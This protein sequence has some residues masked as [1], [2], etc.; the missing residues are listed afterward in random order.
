MTSGLTALYQATFNPRYL[1]A[2]EALASRAEALF[3]DE[4]QQAYLSAPRGMK[5][6]LVET[7]SL[8]DNAWPSGASTL[9]EAQVTLAAITGKREHL[10]R[11]ERY[12]TR[13][14]AQLQQNPIGYGHLLLAADAFLDGA[15]ELTLA[16]ERAAAAPLLAVANQTYAPTVALALHDPEAPVSGL[17][18]E[19]FTGREPVRGKPAAYLCRNFVCERPV[20]EPQELRERLGSVR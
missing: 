13:M 4:R 11:A 14:R 6:L 8:F 20:T 16:G 5:D 10:E 15:A 19:A 9:T 18:R 3:W 12:L 2:A 7:Y 1:E 17:L